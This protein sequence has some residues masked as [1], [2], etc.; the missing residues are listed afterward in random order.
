MAYSVAKHCF[1]CEHSTV[2]TRESLI[3][4]IWKSDRK[5]L[6]FPDN[7]GQFWNEGSCTPVHASVCSQFL[8]PYTILYTDIYFIKTN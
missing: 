4:Y 2:F 1:M 6:I 7:S 5:A 3:L 8:L